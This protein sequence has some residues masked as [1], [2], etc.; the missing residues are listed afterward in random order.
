MGCRGCWELLGSH[1]GASG[2]LGVSGMYWK[3]CRECRYSGAKG[4]RWHKGELEAPRGC[5]ELLEGITGC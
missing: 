1:M 5:R 4:Y 3:A 2:V